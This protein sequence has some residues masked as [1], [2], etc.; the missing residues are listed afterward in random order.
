M[1]ERNK[2]GYKEAVV[3]ITG[4]KPY[5]VH[6]TWFSPDDHTAL[7]LHWHPEI[8][9]C[10]LEKGKLDFY[11]ENIR[12]S[13]K[14]GEAVFVPPNQLHTASSIPHEPGCF[15]AL[16]FGPEFLASPAEGDRF[17]KYVQPVLY[18]NLNNG[19]F[20]TEAVPWQKEILTD[21]RRIFIL[22]ER[23]ADNELATAGLAL[24]I[25]QQLYLHHISQTAGAAQKEE[26]EGQLAGTFQYI[27]EHFSEDI[28]LSALAGNAHMSEGQLCRTFKRLTGSTPF[29][30]LKR[31][32]IL[33]SC[34]LLT[35]SDKKIG[36]I[37][38][39]CGFNNISYYNREFLRLM[40]ITPS[41]YRK[42]CKMQP[43]LTEG[44]K[45]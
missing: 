21:L 16:V 32:R 42:Q 33:E 10:Y 8:E 13:M 9:F 18:N 34:A 29:T 38:T 36:E 44:K 6:R 30:W 37:C 12:Y 40:K 26:L 4:T 25:W 43:L 7:Y 24:V 23:E 19:L 45:T 41:A 35:D 20:L 1:R 11:I 39:L 14:E 15:R 5:S 2:E 31:R 17:R 28:S 22:S 27:R 3:H